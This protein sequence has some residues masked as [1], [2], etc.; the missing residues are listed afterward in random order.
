VA[1]IGWE[2]AGVITFKSSSLAYAENLKP[3]AI[4]AALGD[5]KYRTQTRDYKL[6]DF[7]LIG[8]LSVFIHGTVVDHFK[9]AAFDQEI[10]EPVKQPPKVQITLTRPQ[11][12][13]VAPPPVKAEPPKPKVVPLKP[14]KPKP[15]PK[16][17]EQTPV[18]DP[19]PV[20]D[21]TPVNTAPVSAP[22]APA[23]VVEEKVTAP[24]AGLNYLNSETLPYPEVAVERGL[25]GRV[26]MKVHVLPDGKPESVTVS[27]SSGHQILDDAAVKAV[28]KMTFT[29]GKR[30]SN[31]IDGYVNVPYTFKLS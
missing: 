4:V 3:S 6:V 10:I 28:Y 15:Q 9:G 31:P 11:P 17:V 16:L 24:I 5:L 29:P 25:E 23:P 30:G 18:I 1:T 21:N 12:K 26:V 13:P 14:P 7:L 20:V 2:P 22:T 27:K 19:P 8:V